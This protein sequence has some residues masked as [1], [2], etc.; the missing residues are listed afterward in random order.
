MPD[1]DP[2]PTAV[3]RMREIEA[4][5][6]ASRRGPVYGSDLLYMAEGGPTSIPGGK[7]LG[8]PDSEASQSTIKRRLALEK[9]ALGEMLG[10]PVKRDVTQ[11]HE[12]GIA[13][14]LDKDLLAGRRAEKLGQR[15]NEL[16]GLVS[17]PMFPKVEEGRGEVTGLWEALD[18]P[19]GPMS[20]W[21]VLDDKTKTPDNIRFLDEWLKQNHGKGLLDLAFPPDLQTPPS[22]NLLQVRPPP[23][24]KLPPPETSLSEDVKKRILE[25]LQTR[26]PDLSVVPEQEPR[27]EDR[28]NLP[29][30][31]SETAALALPDEPR[32]KGQEGRGQTPRSV[33]GIPGGLLRRAPIGILAQAAQ[34]GYERFLSEEQKAAVKDF[35]AS[36]A[37]EFVGMEKPGIEYFKDLFGMSEDSAELPMDQASR[38]A[39][40][41]DMGFDDQEFY[42]LTKK[43]FDEFIPGGPGGVDDQGAVFVRPDPS[44]QKSMHNASFKSEGAREM[45]LRIK[46]EAPFYID[47]YNRQEMIDRFKLNSEFPWIIKPDES[48]RLRDLGFDSVELEMEGVVE[49]IA[50]L[51]PANLRA[52][53]SA[54]FDPAKKDLPGLGLARGGF[55]DKP[56]YGN[57]TMV[58]L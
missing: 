13:N 32:P 56:L 17:G 3:Q 40:A 15:I 36:P 10:K 38:M 20:A 30:I 12:Q 49:E 29:A 39:R 55:V 31:I 2:R 54:Q 57:N 23:G 1:Y 7:R 51:N 19:P 37:H 41:K 53:R 14:L 48:Q 16:K 44:S 27:S 52:A 33:A 25:V 42:H 43:D 34:L 28:L 24:E 26:D 5:L 4:R 58:G 35:L 9:Q 50:I 22:R 21:K 45:P 8:V 46:R 11:W 47:E 18:L 6:A